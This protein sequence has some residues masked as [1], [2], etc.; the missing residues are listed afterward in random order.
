MSIQ[1]SAAEVYPLFSS[2]YALLNFM[3]R[4]PVKKFKKKKLPMKINMIKNNSA[5]N[6][7][8]SSTG[9]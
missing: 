4:T 5:G 3:K 2:F 1:P 8:L 6:C 7:L 9:P